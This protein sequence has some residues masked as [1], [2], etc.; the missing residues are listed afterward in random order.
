GFFGKFYLIQAAVAADLAWLAVVMMINS[1]ISIPYY[2]GVV[3]T[4]YLT[5]AEDK[6]PLAAPA[7]LR[8][9]AGIG[10]RGVLVLGVFPDA[11]MQ[12]VNAVQVVP[13]L[14]SAAF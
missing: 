4:M 12:L 6:A 3:R 2:W 7:S 9:A 8:W 1:I 5:E 13:V 14:L 11:F 10:V